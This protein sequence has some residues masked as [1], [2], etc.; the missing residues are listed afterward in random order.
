MNDNGYSITLILFDW[1]TNP[2]MVHMWTCV[3]MNQW[4]TPRR[5]ENFQYPKGRTILSWGRY[6]HNKPKSIQKTY[7]WK[8]IRNKLVTHIPEFHTP[9]H[10]MVYKPL[11]YLWFHTYKHITY[12]EN[13]RK[14]YRKNN[15][16]YW[17]SKIWNIIWNNRIFQLG[18]SI[19]NTIV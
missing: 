12:V 8:N 19:E 4:D 13:N 11:F 17:L 2:S 9:H 6:N 1:L 18:L 3:H 14:N 5:I 15:R 10:T 7:I 16:S